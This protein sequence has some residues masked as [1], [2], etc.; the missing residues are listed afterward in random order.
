MGKLKRL[1]IGFS[2]T[3]LVFVVLS[4]AD[5]DRYEGLTEIEK[6]VIQDMEQGCKLSTYSAEEKRRCGYAVDELLQLSKL[7][8]NIQLENMQD[9]G[10]KDSDGNCIADNPNNC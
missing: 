6:N 5:Y 3:V 8:Q 1:G 2:I 10:I 9:N 4:I 7:I